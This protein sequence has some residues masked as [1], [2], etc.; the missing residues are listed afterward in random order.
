MIVSFGRRDRHNLLIPFRNQG[1]VYHRLYH[2]FRPGE[3]SYLSKISGFVFSPLRY[4]NKEGT[5][6]NN[7]NEARNS[8][9]LQRK[10]C[11][12]EEKD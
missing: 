8:F 11:F 12:L 4:I 1:K 10:A 6:T 7:E 3:L 9:C 2:I 5:F